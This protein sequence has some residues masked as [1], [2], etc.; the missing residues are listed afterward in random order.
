MSSSRFGRGA[1]PGGTYGEDVVGA[2]LLRVLDH[3]DDGFD[4]AGDRCG[5]EA[6]RSVESFTEARDLGAVGGRVE[7][8]VGVA[9]TPV[10]LH[11]VRADVDDGVPHDPDADERLEP[12]GDVRVAAPDESELSH[13]REDERRIGRLDRDGARPLRVRVEVR[14]LDH[15]FVD[16]VAH[17]VLVETDDVQLGRRDDEVAQLEELVFGAV[18]RRHRDLETR[19]QCPDVVRAHRERCL[20][21]RPPQL[22]ALA[23]HAFEPLHVHQAAAQLGRRV[24]V[25]RQDVELVALLDADGVEG[26][27]HP[28]GRFEVV[29]ERAPL[30]AWDDLLVGHDLLRRRPGS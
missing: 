15:A 8:A 7:R 13:R 6:A 11:R 19:E 27:E 30:P 18:E 25:V 21:H 20:H 12:A 1:Q 29:A 23:G 24:V 3:A 22:E 17:P 2:G 28:L 4:R 16:P 9:L 5:R 26:A 14:Q 10:V